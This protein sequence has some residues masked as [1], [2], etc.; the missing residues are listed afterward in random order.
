MSDVSGYKE[1]S[2]ADQKKAQVFFGKARTVGEA[3]QYEFAI[4][5]YL[6]GLAIDPEDTKIHQ[7]LRD[8]SLKRKVSGGKD[9]GMLDKIK[10][11]YGKDDKANM[12]LAEKFLAYD[13][14]NTGRMLEMLQYALK[15]GCYDTVMWIGPILMRA[16]SDSGKPDLSKYLALKDAYIRL[17]KWQ[18]ATEAAQKALSLRPDDMNLQQ[19]VKNLGAQQTMSAGGYESGGSFRDSVRDMDKQR[20]L[21]TED[22]DVRTLNVLESQIQL[23]REELKKDP[24]EPGK[25]S[26]LV[27]VLVKTEDS[28]YE[29]EAIELL[30]ETYKKTGAFRFRL[31][32]GQIKIAQLKRMQRSLLDAYRKNPNDAEA[33]KTYIEFVR[34]KAEE[35]LKEFS[36]AAENYPTDTIYKYEMATR[37]FDLGRFPD[38]IPLLQQSVQDPKLR[39]DASIA[40]GRAFLEAEFVDEAVD[41]FKNLTETYQITGDAKSKLIWYWYGRTLEKRGDGPD[42]IKCYSRVAQWEF[43]YLDVQHRLKA[44][45][46]KA[47]TPG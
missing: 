39:T 37:L 2:E 41:T 17:R 16:I 15:E 23:A 9:L 12:L 31:R 32:L 33:K 10:L 29:N 45:R 26:K 34:E 3:G 8:I 4:E 30:D 14:G 24:N 40:L 46:A 18:H 20:K 1:V 36:L 28:Q 43:N 6:Q 13:P 11:R 25:I 19:E 5:M 47:A 42:A 27:D 21:M 22:T 38:A 44:L 7:A 35:E